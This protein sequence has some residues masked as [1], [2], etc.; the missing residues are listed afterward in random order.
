VSYFLGIDGG[1]SKTRC[2][3]GD[4][5]FVVASGVSGPCNPVRVGL[6]QC[7]DALLTAITQA[8]DAAGIQASHIQSS[9]LGLAGAARAEISNPLRDVLRQIISGHIEIVGDN[10]IALHAAL[11]SDPGVVVISGTGSIAYGRGSDGRITRAGGWGHAISDEGSGTWIGRTAI[12]AIFRAADEHQHEPRLLPEILRFWNLPTREPLVIKANAPTAPDFASL[13][14]TITVFANEGDPLARSILSR[15]GSE[16][17]VLA[18]IAITKIFEPATSV[19]VA[20]SGGVFRHCAQVRDSFV[21]ELAVLW[22]EATIKSDI[23]DPAFGALDLARRAAAN[24]D[25]A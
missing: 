20:M 8:C 17:A 24:S 14:P 19:P 15:A 5:Y 23:A 25:E 10:Q 16:L 9:C 11:G 18:R 3:L 21:H 13:V 4:E 2:L 6:E 22:P 12:A 7:G 1:A